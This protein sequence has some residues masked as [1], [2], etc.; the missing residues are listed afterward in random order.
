MLMCESDSQGRSPAEP[1]IFPSTVSNPN[2]SSGPCNTACDS[3]QD[4]CDGWPDRSQSEE[5]HP[6]GARRNE[7]GQVCARPLWRGADVPRHAPGAR[8]FE[9]ACLPGFTAPKGACSMPERW[10][11]VDKRLAEN[12]Y[13]K[14]KKRSDQSHRAPH[15][16]SATRTPSHPIPP[17]PPHTDPTRACMGFASMFQPAGCIHQRGQD[18][19]GA[20]L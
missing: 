2:P 14:T 20:C 17:Q 4:A 11:E 8:D 15:H 3:P 9:P 1:D 10:S 19:H 18:Y 6:F 13:K 7:D 12:M 16:A 5:P